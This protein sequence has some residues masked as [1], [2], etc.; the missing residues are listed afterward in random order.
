MFFMSRSGPRCDV[1]GNRIQRGG[2]YRKWNYCNGGR[3]C[4]VVC[5]NGVMCRRRVAAPVAERL[6]ETQASVHR[7]QAWFHGGMS[8]D[9]A[10]KILAAHLATD[11]VFLVRES[12]VAGGFVISMTAS[13]KTIH[14]QVL[15]VSYDLNS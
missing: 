4:T 13:N 14:S 9:K 10:N 3:G 12:S 15:P 11:G 2:A 5:Y 6:T 7:S 1:G 8:R